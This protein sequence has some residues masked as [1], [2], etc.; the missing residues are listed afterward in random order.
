MAWCRFFFVDLI[1]TLSLCMLR[2]IMG[3]LEI[4]VKTD[5]RGRRVSQDSWESLD[6]QALLEKRS[7]LL[8]YQQFIEHCLY[9]D[10]FRLFFDD[11]F[12]VQGKLGVPGLPGYP[13]RQGSKVK[14]HHWNYNNLIFTL[15]SESRRSQSWYINI[16]ILPFYW[17]WLMA[18]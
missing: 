11:S 9:S 16:S 3:L 17:G 13:G 6:L 5:Q 15:N 7:L 12:H 4:V 2:V 1:V 8:L 10:Y 18:I 14:H